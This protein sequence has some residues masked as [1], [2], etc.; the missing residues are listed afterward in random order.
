M[1]G[2]RPKSGRS[3][4]VVTCQS[5]PY[6][7]YPSQVQAEP[8][9]QQQRIVGQIRRK[10]TERSQETAVQLDLVTKI[11]GVRADNGGAGLDHTLYAS[12]TLSTCSRP[13]V[14]MA[15][16]CWF[17]C[18]WWETGDNSLTVAAD[19]VE[20]SRPGACASFVGRRLSSN[21]VSWACRVS[22]GERWMSAGSWR[23][24]WPSWLA[25]R[26]FASSGR[27]VWVAQSRQEAQVRAASLCTCMLQTDVPPQT[28]LS[29]LP[30]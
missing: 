16:R 11:S 15:A 2:C 1:H 13:L 30:S 22:A 10:Q 25:C 29:I 21:T 3:E 12:T 9:G 14:A 28:T 17:D 8:G 5:I 20:Q 18:G 24:V 23:G 6:R 19:L 4:I 7:A 27:R 26:C